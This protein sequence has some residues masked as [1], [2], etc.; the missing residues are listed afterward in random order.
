MWIGGRHA[1]PPE[2]AASIP[3]IAPSTMPPGTGEVGGGAASIPTRPGAHSPDTMLAL[4]LSVVL[5][6][7]PIIVMYLYSSGRMTSRIRSIGQEGMGRS[8]ETYSKYRYEGLRRLVR[9]IY[10][11]VVSRLRMM[12]PD[13]VPGLTPRQVE[14]IAVRLGLARPGLA[15]L[16]E[17]Y[18]YSPREPGPRDIEEFRRHVSLE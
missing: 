4:L 3:D 16:Y 13:F 14:R 2:P 7:V 10:L 18:I 6:M 8:D 12:S 9:Q 17:E 5:L 1:L 11:E 15:R